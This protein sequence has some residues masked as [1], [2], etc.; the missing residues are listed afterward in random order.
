MNDADVSK[1]IQQMVAFIRQ[2]AEEK[3]SE[4]SVSAEEEFN[5]EKLQ[6]FESEK[7]KIRQEYEKKEKQVE[8]RKK[9]EYSMQLNASRIKVLQAQD[10]LV[11][12][13]R[14]AAGK[15][16]LRIS[17]DQSAYKKLLKE[18]IIQSLLRL[19]EPAVILRC[20]KDDYALVDSVLD[21]AKKEYATK[22]GGFPPETEIAI[23]TNVFLPPAPSSFQDH[24][25]SCSGGVVLASKDGKIVCENTLDARL[26]VVFRKKLPEVHIFC[27]CHPH[28]PTHTMVSRIVESEM[29]ACIS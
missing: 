9:I 24:S 13:M 21:S 4:I 26:D 11:T 27:I 23:D 5:I 6:L 17:G 12:S 15:E 10:D 18:L 22:A 16:L 25:L 8:I 19:K 20:R 3:A 7:K 29:V 14:E 1:Q 2:E 28:K